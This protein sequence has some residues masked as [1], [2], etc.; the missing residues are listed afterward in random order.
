LYTKTGIFGNPLLPIPAIAFDVPEK[1]GSLH[2]IGRSVWLWFQMN[3]SV[4]SKPVS[5]PGQFLWYNMRMAVCFIGMH[6][7]C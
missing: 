7:L 6:R 4:V 1:L 2:H 3:K 5:P